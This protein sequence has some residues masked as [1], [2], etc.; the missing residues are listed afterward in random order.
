MDRVEIARALAKAQAFKQAGNQE[1]AEIWAVKLVLLLGVSG[2]LN[3]RRIEELVE[4]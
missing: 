3:L 1:Q 4:N 2:I